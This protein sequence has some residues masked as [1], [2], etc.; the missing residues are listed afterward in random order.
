V[1]SSPLLM[2]L[3]FVQ[4]INHSQVNAVVSLVS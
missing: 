4:L 1:A 3:M 2:S